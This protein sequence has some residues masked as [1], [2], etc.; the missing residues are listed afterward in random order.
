[1]EG[2]SKCPRRILKVVIV[3]AL[4]M[5][6][7]VLSEILPQ[8]LIW[9]HVSLLLLSLYTLEFSLSLISFLLL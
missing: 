8:H 3:C 5:E 1:M 7:V 2:K 4:K 6:T 9:A